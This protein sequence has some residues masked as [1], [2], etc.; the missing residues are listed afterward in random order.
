MARGEKPSSSSCSLVLRPWASSA[1]GLNVYPEGRSA[2]VMRDILSDPTTQ[3]KC[4]IRTVAQV[5]IHRG[6]DQPC[7]GRTRGVVVEAEA[8]K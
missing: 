7:A 1:T 6:R 4:E 5:T 3:V 2:F 8:R